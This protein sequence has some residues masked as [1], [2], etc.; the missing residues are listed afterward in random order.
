[1]G[2]MMDASELAQ[3]VRAYAAEQTPAL[4]GERVVLAA[5]GGA[6]SM[7]M[8]GLLCEAGLASSATAVVAHFDHRLRGEG[9]AIRDRAAVE[10]LCR[11][12]GLP[13]ETGAWEEPRKGE[14]AAREA[15]YR[16][17]GEVAGRRSAA[18][19]VTGHTL[20]DQVET[21]MLHMMRGSG[22]YGLA[23]MAPDAPWPLG[24]KLSPRLMRPLL[25]IEREETRAY[26]AARGLR[27][28][29][30]ESNDDA[31][32]LRNRVRRDLLPQLDEMSPDA[33]RTVAQLAEK[34]RAGIVT[35]ER[36]VAHALL[37]QSSDFVRLSRGALREMTS[38]LAPYAYRQALVALLGDA[39]DFSRRHFALMSQAVDGTTGSMLR[40][41]RGAVLTVDPDAIV[42]SIGELR[43]PP[44]AVE[45][46]EPL[47]FTGR[48]GVWHL[49]IA[50]ADGAGEG[51]VLA[52]PAGTVVRARRPG[53]RIQPRGMAGHKKLQD[54][55][56]DRKVP[57][58]ERDAAPVV[59]CGGDVLWTPFGAAEDAAEGTR[60][61][62]A[63]RRAE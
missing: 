58:R 42:L 50:P 59:A 1:M 62:I 22:P 35:L 53:D 11:R 23:G 18:A 14:A 5:S 38:E 46:E 49:A 13:L 30:D 37:E 3:R 32:F 47:P 6:D 25:C 31:S 10:E 43:V 12:Y 20:D 41:P 7:A 33:R 27:Y 15:R 4:A 16:F 55:Y 9:A 28:V 2:A 21:V 40:L 34:T 61:R 24:G 8:A 26:C 54:Y 44:V 39:R 48:L 29:D 17:L 36:A 45:I 60:Y 51:A 63:A 19:V 56:V 52:A 57:R